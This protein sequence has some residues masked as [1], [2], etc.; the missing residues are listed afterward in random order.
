MRYVAFVVGL[1]GVLSSGYLAYNWTT[2]VLKN[3]DQVEK[4]REE[5]NKTREAVEKSGNLDLKLDL[6]KADLL[7]AE[8]SARSKAWPFVIGSV[9]LGI[10]GCFLV[11]KGRGLIAALL[12]FVAFI[13]PAIFHILALIFT[14]LFLLGAILCLS[15]RRKVPV[16]IPAPAPAPVRAP[17]ARR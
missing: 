4:S 16:P 12:M 15:V 9:V 6:A 5:L 2:D 3:K 1:L 17:V 7:Y 11:L 13:L 8:F 14:G 10:L